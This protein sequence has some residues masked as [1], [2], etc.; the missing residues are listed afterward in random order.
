MVVHPLPQ[1]VLTLCNIKV[2]IIVNTNSNNLEPEFDAL[3]KAHLKTHV[4]TTE[5]AGFDFETAS[6]YLERTLQSKASALYEDHLA[7]CASCRN[8]V[9]ELSRLMPAET[10]VA[11]A[12]PPVRAKWSEWFSGWKLGMLAGL[13]TATA[14]ILLFTMVTIQQNNAP[15][16]VAQSNEAAVPPMAVPAADDSFTEMKETAKQDDAKNT[17]TVPSASPSVTAASPVQSAAEKSAAPAIDEAKKSIQLDG[18]SATEGLAKRTPAPVVIAPSAVSAESKDAALQNTPQGQL[19]NSQWLPRALPTPTPHGP[20]VNQNQIQNNQIVMT[21]ASPKQMA[22]SE[23]RQA[24]QVKE[25]AK[26]KVH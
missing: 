9:V 16:T 12:P 17:N 24:E 15:Q 20:S 7:G 10:V 22:K 25:R 6:A 4:T 23:E 13:G 11:V 26:Q 14:A 19:Q 8:Q 1:V 21:E 18:V 3:L 2:E 5:C